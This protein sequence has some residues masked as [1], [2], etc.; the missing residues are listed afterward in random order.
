M[1]PIYTLPPEYNYKWWTTS[2]AWKDRRMI[3]VRVSAK[4][5]HFLAVEYQ[6]SFG[7][8]ANIKSHIEALYDLISS[9]LTGK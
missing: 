4:G 8:E 6:L 1:E 3:K 7:M 2:S 9:E 5:A